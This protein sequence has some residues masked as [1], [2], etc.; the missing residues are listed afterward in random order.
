MRGQYRIVAEVFLFLLGMMF[1]FSIITSFSSTERELESYAK[2]ALLESV[3]DKLTGFLIA[4]VS[5]DNASF[6]FVLPVKIGDSCYKISMGDGVTIEDLTS[7]LKVNNSAYGL[8]RAFNLSGSEYSSALYLELQ[9]R[10]EEIF[11]VRE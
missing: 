11:V 6:H 8:E 7:G 1:A 4:S 9:K 3:A 10:G 2:L 5:F